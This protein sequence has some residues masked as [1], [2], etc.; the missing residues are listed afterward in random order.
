MHTPQ[1][2]EII[3]NERGKQDA[4][5]FH[6]QSEL[7]YT[8]SRFAVYKR[9]SYFGIVSLPVASTDILTYTLPCVADEIIAVSDTGLFI[10]RIGE[11]FALFDAE[12]SDWSLPYCFTAYSLSDTQYGTMEL[13]INNRKGLF[14]LQS[15]LIIIPI[16]YDEVT[17]WPGGEYLWVKQDGSFHFI[18]RLTGQLISPFDICMPFD[19]PHGM[20]AQNNDGILCCFTD[21]GYIDKA[22]YR[23]YII[24]HHGRGTFYNFR[25]HTLYI[26]DIYG[27]VLR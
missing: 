16:A 7:C 17:M 6:R 23:R 26:T 8:I 9:K 15:K 4:L 24:E 5:L 12:A 22:K 13:M 18:N 19:T 14:D 25:T 10:V 27:H 3:V 21:E 20:F 11:L 2:I 1:N